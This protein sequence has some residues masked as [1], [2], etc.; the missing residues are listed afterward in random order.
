MLAP[1]VKIMC[2][3][4]FQHKNSDNPIGILIIITVTSLTRNI[5][6]TIFSMTCHLPFVVIS[7]IPEVVVTPWT[8]SP[9]S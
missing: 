7:H 8:C 5:G 4:H 1:S 9:S 6:M 2:V 3:K